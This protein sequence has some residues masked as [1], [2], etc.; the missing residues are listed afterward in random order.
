M[1]VVRAD[2]GPRIG[3]GHVLRSLALAQAWQERGGRVVFLTSSPPRVAE[4]LAREHVQVIGT[5]GTGDGDELKETMRNLGE[6][7]P[8]AVV[9][10][11]YHIGSPYADELARAGHRTLVIDDDGSREAIA[12]DV[13]NQNL[14]GH[15]SLYPRASGA[16]L[17]GAR[18]A[19]LRRE[20]LSSPRSDRIHPERASRALVTFGGADPARLTTRAIELLASISPDLTI[21][22]LVGAA[23][24]DATL[25]AARSTTDPGVETLVDP[26]DVPV[27]LARADLAIAASGSTTWELAYLGTPTALV[28]TAP[29]QE[30]V[31]RSAARLGIA[32][33]LGSAEQFG[34]S[35]VRA[36]LAHLVASR[37]A[38]VELAQRGQ[39][40]ID[41]EGAARVAMHLDAGELRLRAVRAE[42]GTPLHAW[43]NDPGTRG[44]SFQ[45]API[46]LDDHLRWFA[47]KRRSADAWLWIAVDREERD[48]GLVRFDRSEADVVDIGIT[49][50]PE[51]RG[52][53][54]AARVIEAGVARVAWRSGARR[55]RAFI[56]CDNLRSRAAFE[57]AGFAY[58]ADTV[59]AG[60]SAW[61]LV[62]P[63]TSPT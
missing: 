7:A 18:F 58:E 39:E 8:R 38:R 14:H 34:S 10:D 49:I 30:P 1:L 16:V 44:G 63:L 28:S 2:A 21:T 54:L 13:L 23:N 61:L 41:G 4:R 42:D 12:S 11:G 32:H 43:A 47:S 6:I 50:A 5:R 33:A 55:V 36:A 56:R 60:V 25:L 51:H 26:P 45:S 35:E 15:E 52:R 59:V 31:L 20:F 3:V 62:R 9:V 22:A 29:N 46:P 48:I 27:R 37:A 57:R 53:G 40:L 17:A 24:P 19:M